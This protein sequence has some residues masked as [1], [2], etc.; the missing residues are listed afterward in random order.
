MYVM[1]AVYMKKY[2]I[3]LD[4]DETLLDCNY[5]TTSPT[6]NSVINQLNKEGH[7]FLLNSNRALE[8]LLSVA[9]TFDISGALIGENGAFIYNQMTGQM[10]ILISVEAV[11]QLERLKRKIPEIINNNFTEA[12]LYVGDTTDIN[13]HID[14]QDVPDNKK[15]VFIMNEFRKYSI[16]VHVK[17]IVDG[18]LI[19]DIEAAAKLDQLI[20]EYIQ[21]NQLK[22]DSEYTDSFANVLI[23]CQECSKSAAFHRLIDHYPD[24]LKVFIGDD[25]K[26]KPLEGAADYFFVVHNATPGAK[27]IADYVSSEAIT[28]G[29]EDILLQ[30]DSL[31]G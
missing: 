11:A 27:E 10:D 5:R 18:R 13:K 8:D 9:K 2:L 7:L 3:T 1:T 4:V 20:D 19:K 24:Y 29:V 23:C 26:D 6:I 17:R 22:L 25:E 16:S 12:L 21:T 14:I 15:N 31:T 28:K 30:I